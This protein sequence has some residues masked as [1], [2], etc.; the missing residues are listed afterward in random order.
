MTNE[1]LEKNFVT[2]IYLII[3]L[4]NIVISR[5]QKLLLKEAKYE[6]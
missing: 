3:I 6:Q 1:G 2:Y 4:K 5:A